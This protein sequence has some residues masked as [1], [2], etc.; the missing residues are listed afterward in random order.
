MPKEN[1]KLG[2][3][4]AYA[5]LSYALNETYG[6]NCLPKIQRYAYGKP[7]FPAL[8]QIC[9][10]LTHCNGMVACILSRWEAGID[11]EQRRPVK[12]ALIQKVLTNSER[13]QLLKN[14]KQDLERGFLRYWT[15]KESFIKAIG[16]GLSYPLCEVEFCMEEKEDG[17][18]QISS[19]QKDWC[20]FQTIIEEKFILSA[21]FKQEEGEWNIKKVDPQVLIV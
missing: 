11:A 12:E 21:C 10:N 7:Y 9:F 8:S 13:E 5:L 1:V 14:W 19:N 16:T 6:I 2:H 18:V 17:A 20:F 4:M 15:L 3:T